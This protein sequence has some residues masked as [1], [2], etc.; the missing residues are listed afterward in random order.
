MD[1]IEMESSAREEFG[2]A[3]L[4]DRVRSSQR[5]HETNSRPTPSPK[6]HLEPISRILGLVSLLVLLSHGRVVLLVRLGHLFPS[7]VEGLVF[8][9]L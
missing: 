3:F 5:P 8:L 2:E 1:V 4:W 6:P 7:F 9:A